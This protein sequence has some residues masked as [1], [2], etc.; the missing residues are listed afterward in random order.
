VREARYYPYFDYLRAVAAFGVFVSHADQGR[1]FP[2]NLGNASVQVFFALSG[3]LIGGILLKSKRDD[4][5]RF[6]FNRAVRIWIP[7]AIAILILALATA[8]KQGFGDPKIRE[9]F[10][11]MVTFDYNWF[12]PPQLAEFKHRMPLDGTANHFWSI[13]VEE[14]F[15]LVAPFL[16]LFLPRAFLFAGLATATALSP[17]YFASISLGVL[18]AI[19]GPKGWI[20]GACAIVGVIFAF[21]G[22]YIAAAAFISTAIVGALAR[23]PGRQTT[24]GKI[25]G[26]ASYPFYLN[27]WIGLFGIGAALKIGMPYWAAWSAGLTIAV[28]FSVAHYLLIDR[29]VAARRERW[30]SVKVG[31]GLCLAAF[32]LVLTGLVGGVAYYGVAI[33]LFGR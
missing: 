31:A 24:F 9:F 25:A 12:G 28:A 11:Y 8:G 10:F 5:P 7:Y 22:P 6:F 29:T 32:A 18:L 15:Y 1:L 30:F 13:C 21:I 27:H 20:V 4:L 3:F 17:G 16:I 14:Q 23:L 2:D 19:T 33:S 26:G